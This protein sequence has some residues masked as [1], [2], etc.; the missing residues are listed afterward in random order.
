MTRHSVK[1]AKLE[2]IVDDP[3]RGAG[4]RSLIGTGSIALVALPMQ[5]DMRE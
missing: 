5:F 2:N 4:T 1:N 3:Y